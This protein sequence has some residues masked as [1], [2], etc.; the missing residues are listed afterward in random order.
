MLD[1][2]VIYNEPYGVVLALGPWNYPFQLC[3]IPVTSAIAAGNCVILKP[4]EM[5]AATGELIAQL[6]PKYLD[7]VCFQL[8]NDN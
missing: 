4:S 8:V 5:A 6:I 1:E 2:V 3:M 7:N